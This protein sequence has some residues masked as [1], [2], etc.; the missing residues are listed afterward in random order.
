MAL[1]VHTFFQPRSVRTLSGFCRV[2]KFT[3]VLSRSWKVMEYR[4][5]PECQR[6]VL[7]FTK[8]IGKKSIVGLLRRSSPT[9]TTGMLLEHFSLGHLA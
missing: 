9:T 5:L 1:K 6:K 4:I 8:I 7:E 2:M 3:K